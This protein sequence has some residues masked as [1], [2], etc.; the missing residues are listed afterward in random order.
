[1]SQLA[2]LSKKFPPSTIRQVPV[3]GGVTADYVPASVVIEK[4]LAILGPFSWHVRGTPDGHVVGA[5]T[6]HIDGREVTVEGVG[7]GSDLK[8]AESDAL[9]RAARMVGVGLHLW[10]QD[11]YRLDRAL[12]ET[13]DDD[14]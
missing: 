12:R 13:D 8:S 6:L 1:M 4:L 2:A 14:E 3:G 5:L 11:L 7:E 10:S 9:K